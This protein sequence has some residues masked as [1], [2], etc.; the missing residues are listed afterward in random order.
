VL[1]YIKQSSRLRTSQFFSRLKPPDKDIHPASATMP[2][3]MTSSTSTH[4]YFATGHDREIRS[5][6]SSVNGI[7]PDR[8]LD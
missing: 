8:F 6:H 1:A 4:P 3:R 7:V 2:R 5:S